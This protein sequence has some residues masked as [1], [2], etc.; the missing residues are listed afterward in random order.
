MS[1]PN[2]F[3]AP[4]S[5]A[6]PP[7]QSAAAPAT[8]R[9]LRALRTTRFF[10]LLLAICGMAWMALRLLAVF[11]SDRL[12]QVAALME[13]AEQE[14]VAIGILIAYGA[15]PVLLLM[16]MCRQIGGLL[17]NGDLG[18]LPRV[19]RAQRHFW[20]AALLLGLVFLAATVWLSWQIFQAL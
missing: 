11:G 19:L 16:L 15:I 20:L 14:I 6:A 2:P 9:M 17:E 7:G 4:L 5:P 1:A 3:E 13:L 18:L 10:A 12:P 8:M